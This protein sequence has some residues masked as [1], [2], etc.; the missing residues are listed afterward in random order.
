MPVGKTSSDDSKRNE[1]SLS[2]TDRL[3]CDLPLSYRGTRTPLRRAF[4]SLNVKPSSQ[5]YSNEGVVDR[6]IEDD[7]LTVTNI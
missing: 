7:R 6:Q 2:V 1:Y 3:D 4:A 5:H